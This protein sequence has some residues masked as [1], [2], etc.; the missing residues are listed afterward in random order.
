MVKDRV[1][2]YVSRLDRW[3]KLDT[4]TGRI[5]AVKQR[6]GPWRDIRVVKLSSTR[7]NVPLLEEAADA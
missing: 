6:R 4:R 5:L 3:M 7:S 2:V 1:Q